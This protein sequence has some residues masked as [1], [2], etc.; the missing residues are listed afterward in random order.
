MKKIFFPLIALIFFVVT[1]WSVSAADKLA[2]RK[3]T[4]T[5]DIKGLGSYTPWGSTRFTLDDICT[6]Y[7]EA[8]G[9]AIPLTPKTEDEYNID[10]AVDVAVKLPQTKRVLTFQPNMDALTGIIRSELSAYFLSF[11]FAFEGWTPGNYLLEIGVRDNLGGQVVSQDLAFQ[12]VEPTEAD[13]KA[14]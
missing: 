11:S 10:I 1:P 3:L 2:I 8:E 6:V 13:I 4:F 14:K 5:K 12:L 9:F 7:V